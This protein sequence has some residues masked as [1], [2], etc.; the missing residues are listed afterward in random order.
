VSHRLRTLESKIEKIKHEIIA[1]GPLRPGTLSQQFN[2]C[3]KSDCRCKANP[4]QKHG[5]YYQ[6][7]FT[8][9]GRSSTHFVRREHLHAVEEQLRNYKK[10]RELVEA[11]ATLGMEISQLQLQHEPSVKPTARARKRPAA[12]A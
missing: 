9:Q 12:P 1:L 4:P 10:L 7:S 11:W 3:G 6:L 2:V 5:P 8:W